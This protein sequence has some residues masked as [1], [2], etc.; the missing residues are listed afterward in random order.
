MTSTTYETVSSTD[1]S[2]NITYFERDIA[3]LR[4][5]WLFGHALRATWNYV[6]AGDLP[7]DAVVERGCA[8]AHAGTASE[9]ALS[10]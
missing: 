9:T 10:A 6:D 5:S 1:G 2:E 3:P 4:T 7:P 8:P